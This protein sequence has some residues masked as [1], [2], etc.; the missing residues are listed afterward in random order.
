MAA[1]SPPLKHFPRLARRC[2]CGELGSECTEL[3]SRDYW[4]GHES[5]SRF[6]E[7]GM[8]SQTLPECLFTL[9]N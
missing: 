3:G 7:E 4:D 8:G 2:L 5:S 6:L 1:G 9:L